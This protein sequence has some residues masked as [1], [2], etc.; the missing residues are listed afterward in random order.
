MKATVHR[1][2]WDLVEKVDRHA[3]EVFDVTPERAAQLI[4]RLPEGYVTVD[5]RP[6]DPEVDLST[7]TVA[8]LRA[9]CEERGIE[10]PGKAKK[11]ELIALLEG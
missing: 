3:G 1:L 11:A 9:L 5:D 6:D 8:T 10:A 2:F 4:E 7:L